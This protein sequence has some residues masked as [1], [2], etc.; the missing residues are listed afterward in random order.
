MIGIVGILVSLFEF[1]AFYKG[2][3]EIKLSGNKISTT[4]TMFALW[5]GLLFGVAVLLLSIAALLGD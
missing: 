1:W 2:V 4:Y 3:K 5:L